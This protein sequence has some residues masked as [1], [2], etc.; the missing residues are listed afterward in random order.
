MAGGALP[1]GPWEDKEGA[2]MD[3]VLQAV[4]RSLPQLP[5]PRLQEPLKVRRRQPLGDRCREVPSKTC[6][7]VLR[8]RLNEW[9]PRMLAPSSEVLQTIAQW[10]PM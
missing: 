5:T 3:A 7:D 9:A 10:A 4:L 2:D 6:E 8:D 1:T